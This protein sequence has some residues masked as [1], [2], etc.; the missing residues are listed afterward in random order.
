MTG[1]VKN[2][3]AN[4]ITNTIIICVCVGGEGGV[5]EPSVW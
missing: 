3:K 4:N 1:I 2:T 5:K